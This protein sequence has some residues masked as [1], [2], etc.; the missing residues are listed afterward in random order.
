[1]QLGVEKDRIKVGSYDN[2]TVREHQ[3]QKYAYGPEP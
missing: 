2:W 1:M 3:N